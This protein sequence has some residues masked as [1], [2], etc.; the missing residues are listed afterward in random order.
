[1]EYDRCQTLNSQRHKCELLENLVK[2]CVD[3]YRGDFTNFA[4]KKEKPEVSCHNHGVWVHTPWAFYHLH[5]TLGWVRVFTYLSKYLFGNLMNFKKLE[6]YVCS[7]L[8][9]QSCRP[10]HTPL[11]P[12]APHPRVGFG[13]LFFR[14]SFLVI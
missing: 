5:P 4:K 3:I 14:I 12:C 10:P 1:M 9:P 8:Y 13:F 6:E 11:A 2:F 7:K